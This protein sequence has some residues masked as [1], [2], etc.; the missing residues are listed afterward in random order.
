MNTFMDKLK[1]MRRHGVVETDV[2]E[3]DID[4][5]L[6]LLDLT[7]NNLNEE[8]LNAALKKVFEKYKSQK[9]RMFFF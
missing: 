3:Y 8:N 9:A 5:Q 7:D 1:T 2:S 4:E 6:Q